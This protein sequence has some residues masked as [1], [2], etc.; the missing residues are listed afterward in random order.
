MCILSVMASVHVPDPDVRRKRLGIISGA[1]VAVAA[2]VAAY[3][4]ELVTFGLFAQILTWILWVGP[5]AIGFVLFLFPRTRSLAS[6]LVLGATFT[7]IIA[8]PT[9]VVVSLGTVPNVVG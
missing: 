6:G 2:T 3:L 7:W 5:L 1:V 8:I 4:A 9:C